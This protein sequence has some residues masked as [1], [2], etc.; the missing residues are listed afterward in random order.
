[1]LVRFTTS[2]AAALCFAGPVLAASGSVDALRGERRVFLVS[3]PTPG[4]PQLRAQRSA[5]AGWR[6]A[7][8]DRDVTVIQIVGGTVQGASDTADALRSHY[9]LPA[10]SFSATLVGKDGHVALRSVRALRDAD[11]DRTIDAMPMRRAGQR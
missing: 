9:G 4:D 11:L 6:E 10:G 2:I 8:Q 1:M 7:A 5:I 3:A